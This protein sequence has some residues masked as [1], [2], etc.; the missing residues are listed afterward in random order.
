[1]D[2]D[3][4]AILSGTLRRIRRVFAASR[5]RDLFVEAIELVSDDTAIA[6]VLIASGNPL[7]CLPAREWNNLQ[8]TALENVGRAK[9]WLGIKRIAEAL[10]AC[11]GAGL[12]HG[13]IGRGAIFVENG[14]ATFRLGGCEAAVAISDPDV[15]TA[16]RVLGHTEVLSFRQDWADLSRLASELLG[17]EHNASNDSVSHYIMLNAEKQLLQSMLAPPVHR[18]VDGRAIIGDIAAVAKELARIGTS[19][20]SILLA[21]PDRHVIHSDIPS[22]V[23]GAISPDDTNKLLEYV[24]DDLAANT[25]RVARTAPKYCDVQLI[26]DHACYDLKRVDDRIARIV[27]CRPRASDDRVQNAQTL[28]PQVRVVLNRK[29]AEAVCRRAGHGAGSWANLSGDENE[30]NGL[31]HEPATTVWYALVLSEAFSLLSQ[32]FRAYPVTVHETGHGNVLLITPRIEP[33]TDLAREELGLLPAATAL[34]RE[35]AFD[36]GSVEWTLSETDG[37]GPGP[38]SAPSLELKATM[39]LNG[40]RAYRFWIDRPINGFV[41]RYLRP[42]PDKGLLRSASRRLASVVAAREQNDL[43]RA[44]DD[45]RRVRADSLLA[46]IAS[47]GPVPEDLDASKHAAWHAVTQGAALNLVIG[48]PGVGKSF[49]VA[50]LL[51]SILAKTPDARI[52]VSS[53]NHEALALIERSLNDRLTGR[54]IVRAERVGVDIEETTLRADS[55]KILWPIANGNASELND[56]QRGRIAAALHG[57]GGSERQRNDAAAIL[58]DTDHLVMRSADITLATTNSHRIE[59][60]VS[61][62]EQFDWVIVEEAARASGVELIGPL[63]LGNRRVL[64]G[65]HRQLPP[66]EAQMREKLYEE[67]AASCLLQDA[68]ERL[69]V[70]TDLPPEI[71]LALETIRDSAWLRGDVL[72]TAARLETPFRTIAER[73]ETAARTLTEASSGP[74]TMLR[75]QSRMHPAICALVSDM[76][77]DGA[78]VSSDRVEH[79]PDLVAVTLPN[80]ASPLV[81]LDLP[82][83]SR[84]NSASLE[85]RIGASWMNEAEI[86]AVTVAL[87]KMRPHNGAAATL[88]VL[89]PYKGQVDQLTR[90]LARHITPS[91]DGRHTLHGFESA[92]GDGA[93][94]HTVDGFQGGEADLVIVSLVR[95]NQQV[96]HSAV[97]FL[98]NRQRLNVLLSRARH[99]LVLVTSA[100]FL[101][102][103][104]DGTD[105]DQLGETELLV[106][107]D[108]I[109]G[110]ERRSDVALPDGRMAATVVAITESGDFA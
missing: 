16:A 105:P 100:R 52:L 17:V 75:E 91:P 33:H 39:D 24:T 108:L 35:M 12:V 104:V 13:T 9:I 74:V 36:D 29:E 92:K 43:L 101:R 45:P 96:G 25:T 59:A 58:R 21:Y 5:V 37:I 71:G 55:R 85:K 103:A 42:K 99:K 11:H 54:I 70:L 106:L 65:D 14:P 30:A 2:E 7:N 57:G 10:D 61:D 84:S 88:A 69:E 83:L 95:N 86:N 62:G 46:E 60:L 56:L 31:E 27:G 82:P 109:D 48:P 32:R 50:E 77:Y 41:P 66:F 73:G 6:V 89:S 40:E 78:L 19:T 53:Q 1:M 72:G 34:A 22:M 79:R 98:R 107:R 87:S 47:P 63:L 68:V 93:F 51:A 76:F 38:S 20:D 102:H 80:L 28:V 15:G 81:L 110:I 44:L 67:R 90:R 18:H 3:V 23:S 8:N 4:R 49:F 26:S 94:V 97:G 64:V